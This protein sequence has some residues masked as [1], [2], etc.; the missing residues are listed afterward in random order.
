MRGAVEKRTPH[1][2]P[3]PQGEREKKGFAKKLRVNSTNAERVFWLKIRDRQIEGC[4]FRRQCPIDMYIVD[5][6]CFERRLVVELDGGQHCE[7]PKDK[8]RDK[9]LSD[10]GFRVIRFWNNDVLENMEGVF[11]VL[12]EALKETPSPLAGEGRG[13]GCHHAQN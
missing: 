7:N 10:H 2:A 8:I 3:L 9:Y 4:K 5:F 12:V 13:E 6:V 1:P 11:S